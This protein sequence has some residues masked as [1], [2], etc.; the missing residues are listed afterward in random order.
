MF[1][2]HKDPIYFSTAIKMLKDPFVTR[3]LKDLTFT[4][5]VLSST[6]GGMYSRMSRIILCSSYDAWTEFDYMFEAGP[7]IPTL[8]NLRVYLRLFEPPSRAADAK[9]Q[10][11]F[12]S[13]LPAVNKQV[14]MLCKT[15]CSDDWD[16]WKR[17]SGDIE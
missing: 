12:V 6:C 2:S 15:D 7:G 3:N 8:R 9:L 1:S 11:L 14:T 4:F 10:A 5:D 13:K 16:A 17:W